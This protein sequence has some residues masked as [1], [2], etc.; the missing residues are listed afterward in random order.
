MLY[1]F[2][3]FSSSTLFVLR[4]ALLHSSQV[5]RAQPRSPP[6]VQPRVRSAQRPEV[7]LLGKVLT[8][9]C[10]SRETG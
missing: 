1:F 3:R 7:L 6:I 10:D 9:T 2:V 5:V 4:S 8:M